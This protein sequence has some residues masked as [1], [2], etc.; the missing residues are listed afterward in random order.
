MLAADPLPPPSASVDATEVG[1]WVPGWAP[2]FGLTG[3]FAFLTAWSWRKWA[4]PLT[5]FGR[6]LYQP[7]QL[8]EGR[9]L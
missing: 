4:D 9:L 7:W 8:L 2:L 6:E 5:D 3:L 1:R